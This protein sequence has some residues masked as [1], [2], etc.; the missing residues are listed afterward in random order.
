MRHYVLT[1]SWPKIPTAV[2]QLA[3]QVLEYLAKVRWRWAIADHCHG[4][5]SGGSANRHPMD[6]CQ[7]CDANSTEKD[8]QQKS[9]PLD[10]A[11][12]ILWGIKRIS[13]A[14][15]AYNDA[16]HLRVRQTGGAAFP[17]GHILSGEPRRRSARTASGRMQPHA[18][19]IRRLA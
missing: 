7:H 9:H 15:L 8:M 2:N 1:F 14:S 12:C 19:L 17:P 13:L 6:A 5:S 4:G 3:V 10:P 16:E 18:F 11:T